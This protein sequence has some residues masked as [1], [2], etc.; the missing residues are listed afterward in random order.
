MIMFKADRKYKV[1]IMYS[2]WDTPTHEQEEIIA[3]KAKIAAL[4]HPKQNPNLNK[5]KRDS[6]ND[7]NNCNKQYK[8]KPTFAGE[9]ARK[10]IKPSSGDPKRKQ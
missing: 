3:L 1:C 6:C 10:N 4:N 2:E 9:Q 8:N 5:N 7:F